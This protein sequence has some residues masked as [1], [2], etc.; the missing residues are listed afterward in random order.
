MNTGS[1]NIER[2][3]LSTFLYANEYNNDSAEAFILNPDYFTGVRKKIAKMLNE[4]TETGD[5]FYSLVNFEVERKF[6]AE[7]V[8]LSSYS[9]FTFSEAKRC[10]DELVK[11][12]KNEVIAGMFA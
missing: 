11:A 8:A 5:R 3:L 2:S 7:W 9:S 12:R 6:P 4:E 10:Y 1:L